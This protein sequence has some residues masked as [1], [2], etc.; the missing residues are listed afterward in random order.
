[1]KRKK[2]GKNERKTL[3][4]EPHQHSNRQRTARQL[5]PHGRALRS[6]TGERYGRVGSVDAGAA[7]CEGIGSGWGRDGGVLE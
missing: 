6:V 7:V 3:H 5:E 1:M 2:K 4:K